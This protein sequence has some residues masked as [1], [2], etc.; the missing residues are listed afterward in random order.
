M[1][2]IQ[3]KNLID[4]YSSDTTNAKVAR[5]LFHTWFA[6]ILIILNVHKHYEIPQINVDTETFKN[7][8][9]LL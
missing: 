8:F 2:L 3:T 7:D 1:V 9:K 5:R 6:V 4:F